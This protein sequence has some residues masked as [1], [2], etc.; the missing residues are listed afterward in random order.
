MP[1]QLYDGD[2]R[3]V[4]LGREI[5]RGGE[6]TVWEVTPTVVAKVYHERVDSEKVAKLKAMA[7]LATPDLLRVA[8]WP[9]GT[10]HK[11]PHGQLVGFLQPKIS[12]HVEIHQLYGPA[13]RKQQF[14]KA[15]WSFLTHVAMNCAAAF[16]TIHD[17]RHVIGDVNQ[18]GVF[19]SQRGTVHLIDCDSFQIHDKDRLF[20]C[21]VGVPQYTPPELQGE[22]FDEVERTS[23]HDCFGLA[24]M[25]FHLLFMARHPFA[26]RFAGADE[27]PIEKAIAEGRFAFGRLAPLFQMTPPP[28]S[29][30][31]SAL[32]EPVEELFERAFALPTPETHRPAAREWRGALAAMKRTLKPCPVDKG[33][34]YA[35]HL[36]A[37]P[38]CDIVR[39]GG[40]NFFISVQL[41]IDG[42]LNDLPAIDWLALWKRVESVPKPAF[43][44]PRYPPPPTAPIP[45]PLPDDV[46]D[47]V[48]FLRLVRMITLAAVAVIGIGIWISAIVAWIGVGLMVV[49][50]I[51]WTV[52]ANMP[53][54]HRERSERMEEARIARRQFAAEQARWDEVSKAAYRLFDETKEKLSLV[55]DEG[56]AIHAAFEKER[57]A[58]EQTARQ[59]Q[60]DE[61]LEAHPIPKNRIPQI[62]AG[63]IATL[64]SYGIETAAD[65]DAGGLRSV[66][67]FRAADVSNLL[68]WRDEIQKQF[69]FDP[70]RALPLPR[71]QALILKYRQMQ[72]TCQAK[73]A[74]G[75]EELQTIGVTADRELNDI[76]QR[77][78]RLAGEVRQSRADASVV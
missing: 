63:R 60:Q 6:G 21:T 36:P 68:A 17:H 66:P 2:G 31:L 13:Q 73:L 62:D 61:F 5:G 1:T 48:L 44:R 56:L 18:S 30:P 7:R 38:W 12:D 49:F 71:R 58:L 26:G 40:P 59:I 19:V 27:M 45:R 16:E 39:A 24:V 46:A 75:A 10:L 23:E 43:Q 35:G 77:I 53:D 22:N 65:I 54:F 4:V 69:V 64:L 70:T 29:L 8:A 51:W 11:T 25:I 50:G 33:H 9:T 76:S 42:I 32:P 78:Q 37:C 47:A 74:G 34:V 72:Q 57:R 52:L 41:T 20:R 14:P 3:H 55:R 15:D 28:Y 67:G